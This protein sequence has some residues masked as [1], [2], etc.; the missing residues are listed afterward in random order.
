MMTQA[1]IKVMAFVVCIRLKYVTAQPISDSNDD[2]VRIT[3]CFV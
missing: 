3:F 1:L 2:K